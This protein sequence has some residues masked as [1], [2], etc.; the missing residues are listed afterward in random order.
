MVLKFEQRWWGT[1][2]TEEEDSAWA[3]CPGSTPVP[4]RAS[5]Q[6]QTS[7]VLINSDERYAS[8]SKASLP[9]HDYPDVQSYAM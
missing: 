6:N 7:Y 9:G 5:E 8:S 2:G 3:S 1:G 4:Q